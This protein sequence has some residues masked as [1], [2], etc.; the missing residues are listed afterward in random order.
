[1]ANA[2]FRQAVLNYRKGLSPAQRRATYS[3]KRTWRFPYRVEIK[4]ASAISKLYKSYTNRIMLFLQTRKPEYVRYQDMLRVDS[5]ESEM[6][7]Y[8]DDLEVQ[9][10]LLASNAKNASPITVGFSAD[11]YVAQIMV[12]LRKHSEAELSRYMKEVVGVV[13]PYSDEWWPI[14]ES[15]FSKQLAVRASGTLVEHLETIKEIVMVGIHDET[16]FDEIVAKIRQVN[17]SLTSARANFLARDLTGTF[18]SIAAKHFQTQVLGLDGYTWGTALDERVR[19]RPGGKYPKAVPSHW[20]IQGKLCKWSDP[21]VYSVDAGRTWLPRT[22][23]MPKEHPGQ[24]YGCRCV[25]IP[26]DSE[27]FKEVDKILAEY[28]NK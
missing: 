2:V 7:G 25:S 13:M 3:K 27:M 18:N 28:G 20:A 17:K 9:A 16:P 1:M 22:G 4:L 8:V 5:Y 19:G 15:E 12:E 21:T 14:V 10:A 26:A 6:R 24:G 11:A 23:I